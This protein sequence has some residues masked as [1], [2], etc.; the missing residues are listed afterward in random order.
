ML[1]HGGE[2][3]GTRL[4]SRSSVILM[5]SDHLGNLLEAGPSP[6]ENLLGVKGYTF[7]LGFAVRRED[8]LASVPGRA[9]EVTWG[10]AGGTYFWIDPQEELIGILL[11]QA[12]GARVYYR[13]LFRQLVYA[14]ITD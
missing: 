7:G 1:L 6:G 13:K 4:L 14:A 5:T 3:D 9:G 12:P 2:L 10:G 11:T 8:G